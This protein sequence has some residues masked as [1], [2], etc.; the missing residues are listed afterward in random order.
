MNR[1]II[2]GVLIIIFMGALVP[3]AAQG[4]PLIQDGDWLI[5]FSDV[6]GDANCPPQAVA[7]AEGVIDVP[8]HLALSPD[9]ATIAATQ[10]RLGDLTFTRGGDGS[11]S[12]SGELFAVQATVV[13]PYRIQGTYTSEGLG[14][15]ITGTVTFQHTAG[16]ALPPNPVIAPPINLLD[17]I[18]LVGIPV[19]EGDESDE[20]VV[21]GETV[22][23]TMGS[24]VQL[25]I[26]SDT[27][28]GGD[29]ESGDDER[30][31][32]IARVLEEAL[33]EA[34]ENT[35]RDVPPL[36]PVIDED[37]DFVELCTHVPIIIAPFTPVN[38]PASDSPIKIENV[39]PSCGVTSAPLDESSFEIFKD[40]LN[41]ESD[42]AVIPVEIM[43]SDDQQY[44][45]IDLP[46]TGLIRLD[47]TDGA[48]YSGETSRDDLLI[49]VDL[50]WLSPTYASGEMR[51]QR[52]GAEARLLLVIEDIDAEGLLTAQ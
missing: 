50:A 31:E 48:A 45:E 44:I 28:T 47:R 3:A 36:P 5:T 39:R 12:G 10:T 19:P 22:I 40:V 24:G 18:R 32:D 43:V 2:R 33:E 21:C 42:G 38:T 8:A 51:L 41:P 6:T 1:F 52:G 30:L 9:E 7:A 23:I 11:Y 46:L 16:P 4:D 49:Q 13:S 15:T 14:C 27:L 26:G 34:L 20:V 29:S 25:I 37:Y 35:A 17:Y